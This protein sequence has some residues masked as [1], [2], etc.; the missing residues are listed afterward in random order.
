MHTPWAGSNRYKDFGAQYRSGRES[1]PPYLS[2]SLP[3]C[4][5]FNQRLRRHRLIRWLP[6]DTGPLAKSYPGGSSA[7]SSS[8]HFQSA[9]ASVGSW[10]AVCGRGAT[11]RPSASRRSVILPRRRG[12]GKHFFSRP[13]RRSPIRTSHR[14]DDP[15]SRDEPHVLFVPVVFALKGPDKSAQGKAMRV[16]RASPSPWVAYPKRRRSPEGARHSRHRLVSP[17]QG[18]GT[19]RHRHPGRRYTLPRA[20]LSRPL[21][22]TPPRPARFRTLAGPIVPGTGQTAGFWW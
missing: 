18:L 8:N 21:Q 22:G 14:R 17:L 13:G 19:N 6:L 16:L 10:T 12:G 5:R 4:V 15:V 7:R 3:F 20:D 1:Y 9:R 11:G 2:S